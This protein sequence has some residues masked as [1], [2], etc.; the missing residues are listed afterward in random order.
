MSIVFWVASMLTLVVPCV[1]LAAP[2]DLFCVHGGTPQRDGQT[3]RCP[4]KSLAISKATLGGQPGRYVG[5]GTHGRSNRA[6]VD[7]ATSDRPAPSGD[8]SRQQGDH[9]S[10]EP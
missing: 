8:V 3:W 1:V 4:D 2:T 5:G 6:N 10:P 7:S 9:T